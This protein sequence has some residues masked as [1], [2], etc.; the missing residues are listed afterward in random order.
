[1]KFLLQCKVESK[2]IIEKEISVT[3]GER[4]YIFI[5]NNEGI[6]S[7]IKIISNVKNP[8]KFYSEI[9]PGVQ[10]IKCDFIIKRDTNLYEDMINDFQ[11]LESLLSINNL[12]KIHWETPKEEYIPESK[13][14]KD[15]LKMLSFNY[16]K[17]YSDPPTHLREQDLA[18]TIRTKDRY[19][20]LMIP[21]SF[22]RE[23]VNEFK[24]YRYINAY[25]NFYF[26]IEGLYGSGKTKN[27]DV[28]REFLKSKEFM[29]IAE[30]VKK[31][32]ID[33]D[34]EYLNNINSLLIERQQPYST[35][36]IIRLIVKIRGEIH[37]YTGKK[38]S[39]GIPFNHRYFKYIAFVVQALALRSIL[40][41]TVEI[42]ECEK[43]IQ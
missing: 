7:E 2:I 35:E 16:T 39:I 36:S 22:F 34:K 15:A 28:E 24:Q 38:K 12:K 31:E 3:E 20:T 10:D 27:K 8:E 26:I 43:M 14:E 30:D 23:G 37:H 32:F 5:P 42:N 6:L 21:L 19:E 40:E 29:Q 9:K 11:K 13:E 18:K 17:K 41:K 33:N 1:M 4:A 25:Y